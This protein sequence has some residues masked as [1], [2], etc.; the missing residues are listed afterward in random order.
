MVPLDWCIALLLGLCWWFAGMQ[1]LA[2]LV[3]VY[4]LLALW[5]FVVLLEIRFIHWVSFSAF[6]L[7]LI[8]FL[9]IIEPVGVGEFGGFGLAELELA[10]EGLSLDYAWYLFVFEL[11]KYCKQVV[12]LWRKWLLVQDVL[13]VDGEGDVDVDG[14]CAGRPRCPVSIHCFNVTNNLSQYNV[15]LH[16][17]G[18]KV[19]RPRPNWF[20]TITSGPVEYLIGHNI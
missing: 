9:V 8:I 13:G 11:T 19:C 6:L 4:W 17:T 18:S 16:N 12:P 10:I 5:S 2:L 1:W 3:E 15:W 7:L 14:L 20:N